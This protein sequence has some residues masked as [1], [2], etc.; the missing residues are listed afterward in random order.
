MTSKQQN[1]D[2][3]Q[4]RLIGGPKIANA[5]HSG[6]FARI[7][8]IYI[9]RELYCILCIIFTLRFA[10]TSECSDQHSFGVPGEMSLPRVWVQGD[11]RP[12]CSNTLVLGIIDQLDGPLAEYLGGTG[13]VLFFKKS[14]EKD[15]RC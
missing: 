9:E 4:R 13:P 14:M 3:M 7:I 6:E 10:R 1:T 15:L 2:L 5:N 11:Q 12:S 8:Y